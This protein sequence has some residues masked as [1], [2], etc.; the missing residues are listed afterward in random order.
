MTQDSLREPN[1]PRFHYGKALAL[2][3]LSRSEEAEAAFQKALSL[4][5]NNVLIQRDFAIH[6]F[7]QNHFAE[8]QQ[9]LE[10]L[11]QSYPMDE[12][13]LYYLGRIYQEKRQTDRALTLLE[14]V[15]NLN[16]TFV[17]VYQNLGT[18][19]GE[20]GKLGLAHY[21]LGMHSLKAKAY[22]LA[23]FHFKKALPDLASSDPRYNE[24]RR[25][26]ARLVR[27]RVRVQ[28]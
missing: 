13:V 27:M 15:H 2:A 7:N 6:A 5:P 12:A 26:I 20:K 10:R 22:P 18:L 28:N 14:K 11:A 24:A 17:D 25:Q 4:A 19:Y 16:P 8:A 1:N 21:Y 9:C 23:L 3:K